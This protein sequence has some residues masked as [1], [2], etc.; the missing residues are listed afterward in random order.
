MAAEREG[1]GSTVLY[2]FKRLQL[3]EAEIK[4]ICIYAK[5]HIPW[6]TVPLAGGYSPKI[7]AH[8][9]RKA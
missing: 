1:H 6:G 7:H 8:A 3:L 5:H 2:T 4:A 9:F